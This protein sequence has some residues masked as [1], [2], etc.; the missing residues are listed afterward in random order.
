MNFLKKIKRPLT[1]FDLETTGLDFKTD[2]II[3][4][5]CVKILPDGTKKQFYV[6][7]NPE[8]EIHPEAQKKHGFT[9]NQLKDKKKFKDIANELYNFLIDS[10]L[11]GFNIKKFDLKMLKEEFLKV[12]LNFNPKVSI[13]D[14]YEIFKKF[15]NHT[16]E[17]AVRFYLKRKH[18]DAHSAV[19]DVD[20]TIEILEHQIR[21]Y[22]L[23]EDITEIHS[24]FSPEEFVD[25]GDCFIKKGNEVFFGFGKHKGKSFGEILKNESS[26]LSWMLKSPTFPEDTKKLVRDL[27]NAKKI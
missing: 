22:G 4:I 24:T 2:K 10:D 26:Y 13:I 16:L 15:E 11:C 8:T 21:N 25:S 9:L 23:S 12:G 19:A 5:N 27:A 7:L 20:A 1:F 6:L 14:T 18:V 3:E 17:S